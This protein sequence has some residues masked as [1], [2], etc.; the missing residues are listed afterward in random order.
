MVRVNGDIFLRSI[1]VQVALT[2]F[3]A[4][5]ARMGDVELAA[6][7]ILLNLS[8]FMTYGL[9]GFANAAEAL[10]G[11]AFGARNRA[12]FRAAVAATTRWAVVTAVFFAAVYAVLGPWALDLMTGVPAVRAMAGD[13]LGWVIGLPLVA[14]W[15]Y[16]LDG[17]FIGATWTR[18]MRDGMAVSTLVYVL[19]VFLAVPVFGNHGLWFS[20]HVFMAMRALTLGVRYPGLER[21]MEA[22]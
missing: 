20:F 10:T 12:R 17:I 2:V 14:V 5:G 1:G 22:S 15:C 19:S 6:N 4:T 8:F 21:R 7:A 9:D 13:Y 3:T 11:E 16:H 18:Q